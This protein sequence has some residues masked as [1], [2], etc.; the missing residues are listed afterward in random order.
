MNFQVRAAEPGAGRGAGRRRL[1][2]GPVARPDRP[3]AALSGGVHDEGRPAGRRRRQRQEPGRAPA[4][5]PPRTAPGDAD[6]RRF[7]LLSGTIMSFSRFTAPVY[8]FSI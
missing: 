5:L 7:G 4:L 1:G 2:A 8:G 3:A 6:R